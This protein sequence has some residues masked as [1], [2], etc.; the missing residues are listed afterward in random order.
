MSQPSVAVLLD[1]DRE[2]REKARAGRLPRIAP[3]RFNPEGK[4]WLPMLNTRFGPWRFTAHFSNTERAHEL[5]RAYEWVVILC[6]DAEGAE[7]R[8]TVVTQRHG[9]LVGKRVVRGRE[10][11]CARYYRR[12]PIRAETAAA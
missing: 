5:Q 1:I 9:V 3:R 8:A 12:V 6:T 10:P 2:Y 7:G 4:A 11:E